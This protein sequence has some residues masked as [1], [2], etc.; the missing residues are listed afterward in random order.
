MW[1]RITLILLSCSLLI[2]AEIIPSYRRTTWN[3]G[4][5]GGIPDSSTM[6]IYTN[7]GASVT[8]AQLNAVLASCPSNQ[9]ITLAAGNYSFAGPIEFGRSEGVVLRGAGMTNTFITITANP[10]DGNITIGTETDRLNPAY[11]WNITSGYTKGS[12]SLV[13]S[14][15]TGLP[16]IGHIIAIDQLNDGSLVEDDLG[17]G[18][19]YT[20]RLS[21]E[22]AQCQYVILT[23]SNGNTIGIS[24]GLHMGNWAAA[25]SPQCWWWT[26]DDTCW[27]GVEDFTITNNAGTGTSAVLIQEAR[28]CWVKNIR[29]Y[30]SPTDFVRTIQCIHITVE[31]CSMLSAQSGSSQSYGVTW[32]MTSD[33]LMWNCNSYSMAASYVDA[34]QAM[35]NVCAYNYFTNSSYDDINV[36]WDIAA[37]ASHDAHS[38]MNLHEGNWANKAYIDNDHGSASHNTEFR[39]RYHGKQADPRTLNTHSY[40]A[41]GWCRS[42][43]IV[44]NILGTTG[45]H[46]NYWCTNQTQSDNYG[47]WSIIILGRDGQPGWG[48]DIP[49]STYIHGNWDSANA[50]QTWDSGNEDHTLPD[51]L[52]LTA[53]PSWWGIC[54]WPP[55][56]PVTLNISATN[57]PAGYRYIFGTNPPAG[58]PAPRRLRVIE[59]RVGTIRTP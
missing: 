58:D 43:N 5:S 59:A 27:S 57:I 48:N 24:P 13:L 10:G 14:N 16:K 15:V 4:V 54:P 12:T 19:D 7:C 51:S 9:V 36:N 11:A 35:G 39:N 42:N 32:F 44:G 3:P 31:G 22:R 23:S 1:T 52:F 50:A 28:D 30:K 38:C 56:D 6:T 46:T 25:Q 41:Q 21:G 37:I 40:V 17:D 8:L 2:Q 26:S 34:P 49:G 55:Y 47:D 20:S 53:K 29:C 18:G 45:Y 33:S